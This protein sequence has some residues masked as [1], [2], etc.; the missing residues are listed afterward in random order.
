MEL[1]MRLLTLACLSLLCTAPALAFNPYISSSG[2][3][4]HWKVDTLRFVAAADLPANLTE[5]GVQRSLEDAFAVWG[6]I[7]CWP[8]TFVF[9]GFQTDVSANVSDRVNSIVWVHNIEDWTD[10]YSETELART[11]VTHRPQSG[12][13]VDAD[14]EVNVAGF[15][16]TQSVGCAAG[17]DLQSTMAHEAGHFVGLDHSADR[18]ATMFANTDPGDCKKRQLNVDDVDGFCASYEWLGAGN[19]DTANTD[20]GSDTGGSADTNDGSGGNMDDD[21]CSASHSQAPWWLMG[22]ILLLTPV[23][24]RSAENSAR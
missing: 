16:F 22:A 3:A 8:L 24:R 13:I 9:D 2:K 21:G 5:G 4:L 23:R 17:W 6:A 14:I 11:A 12:E 19:S 10:R 1:D 15:D 7:D 20:T 18:E